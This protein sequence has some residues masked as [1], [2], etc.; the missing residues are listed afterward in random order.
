MQGTSDPISNLTPVFPTS[1]TFCDPCGHSGVG[2]GPFVIANL[3]L[4]Q[5][6]PNAAA[7]AAEWTNQF[8]AQDKGPGIQWHPYS[9][10][11]G[12]TFEEVLN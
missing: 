1:K 12:I 3:E 4:D 8:S 11:Q 2:V 7:A 10:H 5:I 9:L 6:E